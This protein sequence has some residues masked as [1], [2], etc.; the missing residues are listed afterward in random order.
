MIGCV[1]WFLYNRADSLGGAGNVINWKTNFDNRNM[2]YSELRDT[3]MKGQIEI[4]S[5]H[6]IAQM[7]AI[8]FDQGTIG[9]GGDTAEKDDLVDAIVLAHHTWVRWIRDGMV[10]NGQTWARVHET[11]PRG[12]AG[13]VLSDAVSR[14]WIQVHGKARER[15]ERF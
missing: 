1:H 8:V 11:A 14:F 4:R 13:T 5:S 6:T 10:A 7:Q 9:A 15:R 12:D 2:V 3:L